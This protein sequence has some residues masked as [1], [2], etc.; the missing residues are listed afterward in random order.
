[1]QAAAATEAENIVSTI[2]ERS[3]IFATIRTAADEARTAAREAAHYVAIADE[4]FN[5]AT[6]RQVARRA[7]AAR[8]VAVAALD[9]IRTTIASS[10]SSSSAAA[11]SS[12]PQNRT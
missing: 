10:A 5:D 11:A 12:N 3:P 6:A 8:D 4:S 2:S 9:E 1:M 7:V